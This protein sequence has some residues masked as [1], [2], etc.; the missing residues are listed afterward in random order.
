VVKLAVEEA[1]SKGTWLYAERVQWVS[2]ELVVTELS[3]A[4]R[5]KAALSRLVVW[6]AGRS[7]DPHLGSLDAIHLMTA[8]ELPSIS[9]FVTYDERQAKAA[10]TA[11][12][13]VRSPGA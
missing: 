10:R 12:L 11:G 4:I 9:A 7:F 2:S 6:R 1:E 13:N 8:L 5:R 3:R